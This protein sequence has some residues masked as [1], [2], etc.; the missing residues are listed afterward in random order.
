MGRHQLGE[1]GAV[2]ASGHVVSGGDGQQGAGVVVEPRRV[3]KARRLGHGAPVTEHGLVA[4]EEPPRRSQEQRGVM[5]RQWCQLTAERRL[6]EGE[7]DE[8]QSNVVADHVEQR[9]EAFGE[10]DG[11]GDVGAPVPT[12][13]L[14]EQGIVIAP[15]PGVKLHDQAVVDAH[16]SHLEQQLAAEQL[17]VLGCQ[18][19][20]PGSVKELLALP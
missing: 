15:R 16:A 4:V 11:A 12:E 3:G 6:V 5:A 14:V 17:L 13:A 7:E 2:D 1:I 20:R 9:L 10:F 18:G 19:P 8:A